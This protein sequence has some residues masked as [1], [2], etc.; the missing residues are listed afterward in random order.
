MR[1]FSYLLFFVFLFLTACD[2]GGEDK[3]AA[4]DEKPLE[5][6]LVL[7]Q[8]RYEDLPRWGEDDLLS[9]A[10]AFS[11]TCSRINKRAPE[12]DFGSFKEAGRYA[13][14][15]SICVN[16]S[17]IDH[18]DSS[19]LIHFFEEAFVP[20]KVF[21]HD[22][23][24]G[25]FTG[26]YEA[27]LNGSL[28]R[29]DG[30]QTPLYKRAEDLVMVNLGAFRES[31][32]GER[33]AGRVVGGQLKPYETRAE[34]V[35]GQWPHNDNVLVWVDDPVDA[36]FVQIQG[37][38]IVELDDGQEMRIGYAGQN[39][40]PYYAIGRELIK[41]N[42]LSKENVSMQTIRSWLEQNP[43][44]ADEV[45]NKNAS[46]VFFQKIEGAGPLGAEG[47]ALTAGR[48]LAVDRSF[49][50]YGAPLW[51]DIDPPIEGAERLQHLMFAQDTGGAI[52]GPVRGDVF[53]G[54]G[55]QAE[56]VAGKMNATGYYWVLLPRAAMVEAGHDASISN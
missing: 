26:Y 13:D 29:H 48:S 28:S 23:D 56:A 36:F 45:M 5:P 46:Y 54:H 33:I 34:I 37:S 38:G 30:Y 51:V 11:R 55:A 49:L 41:M 19:A 2:D 35:Q 43:E 25:L 32:K 22:E 17:Q 21:N 31:L 52:R 50:P 15:H 4:L 9:A 10:E 16:F 3:N 14:W 44:R 18:S 39:G 6:R 40:H 53:W 7:E 42:V 20:Y 1:S 24:L 12:L 47:V 8:A 27:S